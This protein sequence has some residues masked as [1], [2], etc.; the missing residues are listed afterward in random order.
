MT[1]EVVALDHTATIGDA[2]TRFAGGGH[3]AYPIVDAGR[4]VGIVT[5]G[6]VL[7]DNSDDD[8]PVMD[9]A[10][11]QVLTVEADHTAQTALRIMV[12]EHVEHVPVIDNT[13]RLVGIC[14]RTDL[15]K[16]R[17]RQLDLERR[18]GGLAT[19]LNGI[20]RTAHPRRRRR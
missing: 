18:Q 20:A 10:S 2:R 16:V 15:L 11:S 7:R 9:H 5:R 13:H 19:R 8:Q 4:L 12:D 3:G 1:A 17:R 14:T 6:D